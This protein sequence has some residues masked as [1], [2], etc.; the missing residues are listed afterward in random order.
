[1]KESNSKRKWIGECQGDVFFSACRR[2]DLGVRCAGL[3]VGVQGISGL[4]FWALGVGPG[5]GEGFVPWVYGV[6]TA[7]ASP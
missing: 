3:R 1:M 7:T 2:K 6:M 4:E 5:L